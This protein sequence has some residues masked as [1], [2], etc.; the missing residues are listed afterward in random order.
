MQ[1]SFTSHALFI[2][3]AQHFKIWMN[4]KCLTAQVKQSQVTIITKFKILKSCLETHHIYAY[5]Y[6]YVLIICIKIYICI[7]VYVHTQYRPIIFQLYPV[8]RPKSK[9]ISVM[10][11]LDIHSWLLT[12]LP[13]KSLLR[14]MANSRPMQTRYKLNLCYLVVLESTEEQNQ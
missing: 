12:P 9:D 7:Y 13:T 4:A 10:R 6:V 3:W 8:K 14:K 5:V 11:P 2:K 1:L